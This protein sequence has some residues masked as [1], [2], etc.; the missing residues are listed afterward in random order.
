MQEIFSIINAT[1][2][3]FFSGSRKQSE[4]E[5]IGAAIQAVTEGA[6]VLDVGAY[7]TRP[8]FVDVPIEEEF[9]RLDRALSA[10]RGELPD[11]PISIDT[12]R[13]EVVKRIYDKY[14]EVI[15]N[16]IEGGVRDA[17]MYSTVGR[18][19][20]RYVMMSMQSTMAEMVEFFRVQIARAK[21]CGVREI[22]IDPGFGFGKTLEQ[23]YQIFNEMT[24]LKE[25]FTEHK[26]F[27]GVSRKSMIFKVLECTPQDALWG[28][29][30]LGFGALE[31]GAD[32]LRVHDTLPAAHS[33][34]LYNRF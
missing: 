12:F 21:E 17:Q 7:S 6:T 18:L 25:H 2:D 26:L 9:A 23:N 29:V 24:T 28:T 19:G 31:R 27:V 34:K 3:S 11:T 22:D 10:I 33:I 13:S 15:V 8:G 30:A 32:I 5:I 16:D 1:P 4:S 14:G 20:L